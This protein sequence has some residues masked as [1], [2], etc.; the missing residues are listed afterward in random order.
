MLTEA[1]KVQHFSLPV[2]G[3][4]QIHAIIYQQFPKNSEDHEL[5]SDGVEFVVRAQGIAERI[6]TLSNEDLNNHLSRF[7]LDVN[8][9][10]G[11]P[12]TPNMLY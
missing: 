5:V 4:Q 12:Y 6:E 1:Q 10:D 8:R 9:Q 11:I 2:I 3:N 7:I